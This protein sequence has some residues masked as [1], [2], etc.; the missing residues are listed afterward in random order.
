MARPK[1]SDWNERAT[2]KIENA[3]WK[4]LETEHYADIT[5]SRV[6]QESGTNRNSFYYHYRDIEDLAYHAF[7]DN[8][9]NEI[10]R[11]LISALLSSFQ[12]EDGK[13]TV[14]FD[15]SIL[16]HSK[17]IMLCARSDSPF[18]NQLVMDLLKQIW[19][20]SLSIKEELLTNEEHMQVVFIFAGLVAVLGSQEIQES[21]L[22]MA[23]LSQ[24]EIGKAIISTMK[25]IAALQQE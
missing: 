16:P 6:C 19:F 25:R 3:F 23:T 22:S 7:M 12:D 8:A 21:P 5:V 14:I 17:R 4:L 15:P 24:T 20:E 2:V 1:K 11:T 9:G 10:S 18:M 13:T